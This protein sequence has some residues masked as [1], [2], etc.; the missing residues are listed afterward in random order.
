MLCWDMM[1]SKIKR[2]EENSMDFG[3]LTDYF[4]PIVVVACL[5]VGYIIKKSLD[6]I[7]NKFIPLILTV[8]GMVLACVASQNI[9]LQIVVHGAFSGLA[10]TGLHQVFTQIIEQQ[11]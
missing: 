7:P 1:N 6:F 8:C 9:T 3:F 4:I 2:K 10:S 11:I 5:I